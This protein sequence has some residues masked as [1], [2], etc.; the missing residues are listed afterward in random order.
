LKLSRKELI[1]V[2]ILIGTD[3]NPNGFERVGPKTAIKMIKEYRKL[4]DIPSIRE[5]LSKIDY[6]QIREIF[7]QS[8]AAKVDEIKFNQIDYSGIVNYLVNERSFSKDRVDIGLNRLKK[9]LEK[10]SQNL[11]QWF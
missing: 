3:F 2:G 8:K 9:A 1:D 6:K 4:E 10:K 7:L 11:E 5:Q